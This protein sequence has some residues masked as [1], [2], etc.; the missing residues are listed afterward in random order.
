M[1]PIPE[2]SI[3]RMCASRVSIL[4]H[5]S[6]SSAA[7]PSAGIIAQAISPRAAAAGTSADFSTLRAAYVDRSIAICA[8]AQ[9]KAAIQKIVSAN[10]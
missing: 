3:I 5:V 6:T 4:C 1:D 9:A 2:W 8:T 10:G 7:S